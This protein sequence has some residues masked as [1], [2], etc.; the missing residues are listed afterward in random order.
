MRSLVTHDIPG[1]K[2]LLFLPVFNYNLS[3]IIEGAIPK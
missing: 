2:N 1:I 3:K